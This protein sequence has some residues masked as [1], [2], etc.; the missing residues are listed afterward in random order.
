MRCG[1]VGIRPEQGSELVPGERT[2]FGRE[3]GH[4]RQRLARVDDERMARDDDVE[5]AEQPDME[6]W[7]L[8]RHRVTVPRVPGR[9]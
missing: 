8:T 5:R 6:R 4:D 3:E 2:T 1:V 9:S 7:R